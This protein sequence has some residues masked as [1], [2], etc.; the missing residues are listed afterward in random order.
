MP[1]HVQ[2]GHPGGLKMFSCISICQEDSNGVHYDGVTTGG[3]D[4]IDGRTVITTLNNTHGAPMGNPQAKTCM[5][6]GHLE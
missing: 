1:T 2:T 4:S 5:T 3:T 6:F